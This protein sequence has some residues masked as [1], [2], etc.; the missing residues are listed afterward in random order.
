MRSIIGLDGERSGLLRTR[1]PPFGA[2]A[3]RNIPHCPRVCVC[4]RAGGVGTPVIA[5]CVPSH[6]YIYILAATCALHAQC[7]LGG[8]LERLG[9]RAKSLGGS[10]KRLVRLRLQLRLLKH[11]LVSFRIVKTRLGSFKARLG[12]S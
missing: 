9:G 1:R 12:T 7:N 8:Y 5:T 11:V 6:I 4:V 10:C 2:G 3:V